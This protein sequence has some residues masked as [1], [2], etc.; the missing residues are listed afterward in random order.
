M[1]GLVARGIQSGAGET[2]NAF[3]PENRLDVESL[4]RNGVFTQVNAP[5]SIGLRAF[6]V[7]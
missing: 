1:D 5:G 6:E 2:G 4:W 7:A 3:F